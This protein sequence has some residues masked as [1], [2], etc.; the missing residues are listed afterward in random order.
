MSCHYDIKT[1]TE[2]LVP[3][4]LHQIALVMLHSPLMSPDRSRVRQPKQKKID[5]FSHL[6]IPLFI[7]AQDVREKGGAFLCN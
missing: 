3:I 5:F 2:V 4:I 1:T 6:H 7:S